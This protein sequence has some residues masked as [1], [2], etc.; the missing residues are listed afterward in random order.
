MSRTELP[1]RQEEEARGSY[2]LSV[3][4]YQLSVTNNHQLPTTNYQL[5]ITNNK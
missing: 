1:V 5:P 3:I 4:S 2:Q